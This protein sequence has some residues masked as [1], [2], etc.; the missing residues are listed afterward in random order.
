MKRYAYLKCTE[1]HFQEDEWVYLRLQPYRQLSIAWC[2]NLKLSPRFYG[3]FQILQKV[4]T[5]AYH[6]HLLGSM[7]KLANTLP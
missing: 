7:G 5:V 4:G 1:L 6:L 3:P 2:H